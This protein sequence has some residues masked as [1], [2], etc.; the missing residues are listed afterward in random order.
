MGESDVIPWNQIDAERRA[1]EAAELAALRASVA[2]LEKELS[3]SESSQDFLESIIG[4]IDRA[5]VEYFKA[6]GRG[7][8]IHGS[9]AE[10][11]M[12]LVEELPHAAY[13]VKQHHDFQGLQIS[14]DYTEEAL[15]E[16]VKA[17]GCSKN[18]LD[19]CGGCKAAHYVMNPPKSQPK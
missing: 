1:T 18:V 5:A 17:H 3:D 10:S 14:L 8:S 12:D 7:S 6:T 19:H 11:A 2:R 4:K 16:M 9:Y 13:K 15:A